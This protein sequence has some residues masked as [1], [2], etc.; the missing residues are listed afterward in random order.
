VT[1]PLDELALRLQAA[2]TGVLSLEAELGR[3]GM[4]TVYLARDVALDRPVAVKLLA[5]SLAQD[6][7]VRARFL[8]EARTGARLVH[9]DIVPIYDVGEA[10]GLVWFVMAYVD[11]E[12]LVERLHRTGP[13]PPDEIRR[14]LTDIGWALAAAHASGVLHRDV[15]LANVML[16]RQTGRALLADFGLALPH[17]AGDGAPLVGTPE[18]LAPELLHHAPPSPASDLYALGVVGWALCTGRLPYVGETPGAILL[19]RLQHEPA[20]LAEAAPG[21]PRALRTSIE[22]ALASDP[23]QRPPSVETWLASLAPETAAIQLAT[24][25]TRWL[26]LGERTQP[27]YALALLMTGLG[28]VHT[29][30]FFPGLSGL[31]QLLTI[32]LG[33]TSLVAIGHGLAALRGHHQLARE[34]FTLADLRLALGR[35]RDERAARGTVRAS[36]LGRV[37]NDLAW[38]SAISVFCIGLLMAQY[39]YNEVPP[40]WLRTLWY[41]WGDHVGTLIQAFFLGLAFNRLVPATDRAPDTLGDKLR[42][43]IW[44]SPIGAGWFRLLGAGRTPTPT[45]ATLHRPTEVMLG[46]GIADLHAALPAPQRRALREVPTVAQRLQD[47]VAAV[48]ERLALLERNAGRSG[49]E[50]V[51]LRERLITARDEAISALERLRREL[52]RLGEEARITGP[53]TERLQAV[54][55]ADAM[56]VALLRSE[57]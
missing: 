22:Q 35:A 15:T 28:I 34:G 13:L 19:Q 52:L 44:R 41:L 1:A 47:R 54:K 29:N 25:L 42:R 8:A 56:V 3:G 14:I 10:D 4:G 18:Y 21:T 9:P 6:P 26:T 20:P 49:T 12:S 38:L 36:T 11:G 24:P 5:P 39:G 53:L 16:E 45:T 23:T 37:V 43:W 50:V 30:T 51:A 55:E 7:E 46:L 31:A 2:V 27:F 33:L 40:T 57:G 32:T 17:D 48:R